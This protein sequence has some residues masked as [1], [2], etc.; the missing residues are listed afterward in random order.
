M[1]ITQQEIQQNLFQNPY[2]LHSDCAQPQAIY[3]HDMDIPSDGNCFFFSIIKIMNLSISPAQVRQQLLSSPFIN[4]CINP[5]GARS[6]LSSETQYAEMDCIDIFSKV[7]HQNVCVHNHYVN[8]TTKIEERQFLHFRVND[9]QHFLHLHLRNVHFTPL[10]E[11]QEMNVTNI[12]NQH[13]Q[14][15]DPQ[16]Y[17]D[18]QHHAEDSNENDSDNDTSCIG[19]HEINITIPIYTSYYEHTNAH[20]Q[21]YN[22]FKKNSFGHSCAICD[23][24]WWEKDLKNTTPIHDDIL[25]VILPVILF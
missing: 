9:S 24:L 4:S 1:E 12:H 20:L 15:M 23:R 6:I 11:V 21:F 18:A 17:C 25:Q 22:A 10:I 16:T 5:E 3:Y 19:I 2:Q 7:Y 13:I 8:T 14:N